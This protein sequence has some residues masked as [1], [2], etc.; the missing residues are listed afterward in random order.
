M[1]PRLINFNIEDCFICRRGEEWYKVRRILNVKML[2]PKVVGEYTQQLNEVSADLLT[3]TREMLDTDGV[4][5]SIQD[6]LFKWSL[7][8]ELNS[9]V[10]Y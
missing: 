1:F 5:P 9:T 4:V 7:E 10:I 3:R 2:K 6:E 8:C